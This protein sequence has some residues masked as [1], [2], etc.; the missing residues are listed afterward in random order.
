M[1]LSKSESGTSSN[2]FP[3]NSI[4]PEKIFPFVIIRIIDKPS[5]LFPQALSPAIPI[6]SPFSIAKLTSSSAC[7]NPFDVLYRVVKFST[8]INGILSFRRG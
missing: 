4:F 7:T 2:D 5:V 6:D 3:S 8:E 1:F